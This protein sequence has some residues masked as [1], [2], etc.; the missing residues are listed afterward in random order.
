MTIGRIHS[1]KKL[2]AQL[3]LLG[4]PTVMLAFYVLRLANQYFNILGN[5]FNNQAL[6]FSGG[7]AASLIFYAFRFRFITTAAVLVGVLYA[8][9]KIIGNV[10]LGEFDAFFVSI[11]FFLF[12]FLFSLGWF[13]GFGFSR[14]RYFTIGWSVFLLAAMIL[15]V[16]RVADVKAETLILAFAPTLAYSFYII[17]MSELIRNMNEDEPS[18]IWYIFKRFAAFAV[19]AS[20]LIFGLL[21]YLDDE[22]KG[23]EREFGGGGKAKE[24]KEGGNKLTKQDG[25]GVSTQNQMGLTGN[26]QNDRNKQKRLLFVSKL[27]NY[28]ND[29]KT[30]NPLYY[31]TDYF[32]KYDTETQTFE[33]DSAAPYKDHFNP[34]PSKTG[35]YFTKTDTSVLRTMMAN[36][37]RKVVTAEVYKTLL[38]SHSFTAPATA[39]FMQPISVPPEDSSKFRSAYRAK[40]NVSALNSAYFVYNPAG[41]KDLEKFQEERFRELRNVQNYGGTPQNFMQYYTTMPTGA[42]YDSI[43][44]L[45]KQIV[46]KAGAKSY[47]DQIIAMRNYFLAKD[48]NG[49]PTFYYTDNPGV[50]GMPSASKLN[51]FLFQNKKGYCAY[52][53][54]ATLFLL[55]A[56]G[57]PSRVATGFLT[58]DR[59][60]KNPGWYFFYEDQAHAWVQAYFPGYGW[61]DF[62]TT[63]PNREQQQAPQPDETP[64]LTV[65]QAFLVANGKVE[66]VDVER[67]TMRLVMDK[68]V[69]WDDPYELPHNVPLNLDVKIARFI[70]DTG[71]ATIADVKPGMEI[72]AVSY[73]E[74]FKKLPPREDDDV[75]KIIGRFPN[76]SPIDEIKLMASEDV[77]RD[78]RKQPV[79]DPTPF[80]WKRAFW[81]GLGTIAFLAILFLSLPWLVFQYLHAKAKGR[82]GS[83]KQQAYNRFI[84]STY[85]LNQVGYHREEK[86][87]L[88]FAREVVDPTFKTALTPFMN[89]YLKSKYS[90][91]PLDAQD[92]KIIHAFYPGIIDQVK[93]Q[94]PLGARV[95]RFTNIY[96]MVR[97][98]VKP[99]VK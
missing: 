85:Y 31:I 89:T 97:Y 61:I 38:S 33:I 79:K 22:F 9:Y 45:A 70:K 26:N 66:S 52:Y 67:K 20:A 84:A 98:F 47:V 41:E 14:A 13:V 7:L 46:A 42:E 81:I 30:P 64:P 59:S 77:K 8:G 68:M 56:L 48:E 19:V 69:Y 1:N 24:Q 54:G 62:D 71:A 63:V 53:A 91:Q 74:A 21:F 65:Q 49:L 78:D 40:M 16:S 88:Q 51:Y 25:S 94:I 23:V 83:L 86:T 73:A 43:R 4:T 17:Y 82:S 90:T 96:R 35:L 80:N 92:E 57:I 32:T 28:F 37:M 93:A 27:D 58:V 44:V 87:S 50:P 15:I 34:D 12:A 72:V 11:K 55:R 6:F 95:G 10:S 29:G 3:L 75:S 2:F 36:K 18:F 99:K 39:Y 76:P 60:A 5:D